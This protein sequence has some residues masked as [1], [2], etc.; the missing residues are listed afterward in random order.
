MTRGNAYF[1]AF[2]V[3]VLAWL[4]IVAVVMGAA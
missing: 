4:V 3:A 2:C 1:T